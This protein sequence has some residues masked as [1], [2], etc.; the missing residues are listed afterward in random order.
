MPYSSF[1]RR[2]DLRGAIHAYIMQIAIER[3]EKRVE[4][5]PLSNSA[6][7]LHRRLNYFY[8]FISIMHMCVY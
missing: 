5:S 6:V 1:S 8:V 2:D 4:Q 3:Q 7:P